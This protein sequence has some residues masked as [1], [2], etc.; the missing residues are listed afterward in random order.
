MC[1]TDRAHSGASEELS[2]EDEVEF[3]LESD[4]SEITESEDTQETAD[5][6]W[7]LKYGQILWSSTHTETPH[8][9]PAKGMT[10]GPTRYTTDH[11][12]SPPK[13]SFSFF[14]TTPVYSGGV[15]GQIGL[16]SV[17]LTSR[18]TIQFN[19]YCT[20]NHGRCLNAALFVLYGPE[21]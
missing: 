16:M 20:F 9:H 13:T 19:L 17:P 15:L 7:N 2:S 18:R 14:W 1:Y 21:W 8:C 6:Q 5:L 3:A 12:T 11:I 10:R 4:P